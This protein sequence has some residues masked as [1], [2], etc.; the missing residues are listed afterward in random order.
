MDVLN[1]TGGHGLMLRIAGS[2]MSEFIHYDISNN[3]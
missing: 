1:D 2:G 3:F